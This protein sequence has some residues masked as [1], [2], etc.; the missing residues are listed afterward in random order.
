MTLSPV[1]RES[2]VLETERQGR[3]RETDGGTCTRGYG[4]RK[5][6]G[7]TDREERDRHHGGEASLIPGPMN[8]MRKGDAI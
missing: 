8:G 6:H 1:G 5:E 2:G 3:G 7:D 4:H